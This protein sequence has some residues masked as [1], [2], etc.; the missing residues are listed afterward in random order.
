MKK[1]ILFICVHNSARSQ[2]AEGLVN[3]LYGERFE[4]VSGGTMA[5]RVHPG[6]I[7]AMAEIGI[8]ISG[9]R[10]KSIDEF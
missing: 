6:A 9:H 5:T 7:K 3:A 1:T 10:S 4:A 8:D 2:I